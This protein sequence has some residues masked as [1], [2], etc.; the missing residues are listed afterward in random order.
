[1]YIDSFTSKNGDQYTLESSGGKYYIMKNG[2]PDS[3]S[4]DESFMRS[5]FY[6]LKR[7]IGR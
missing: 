7:S 3:Y 2:K 4:E 6:D 1:M 5:K